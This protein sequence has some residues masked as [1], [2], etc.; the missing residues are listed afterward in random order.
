MYTS[1]HSF[2]SVVPSYFLVVKLFELEGIVASIMLR[3]KWFLNCDN[4]LPKVLKDKGIASERTLRFVARGKSIVVDLA[5]PP[6]YGIA[7][8]CCD[9]CASQR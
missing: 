8:G 9:L 3:T 2:G 7:S 6:S 4:Y 5:S 1:R